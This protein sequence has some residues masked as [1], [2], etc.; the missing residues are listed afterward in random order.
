MA[1]ERKGTLVWRKHGWCALVTMAMAA[2]C[3][4]TTTRCFAECPADTV[5]APSGCTCISTNHGGSNIVGRAFIDASYADAFA[6]GLVLKGS[7]GR[8]NTGPFNVHMKHGG[9]SPTRSCNTRT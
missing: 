9:V 1:R 8:P 7:P 6:G 4:G 5:A 3:G 2:S